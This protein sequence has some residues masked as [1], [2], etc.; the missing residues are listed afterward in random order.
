MDRHAR[1]DVELAQD[2]CRSPVGREHGGVHLVE[3]C[4]VGAVALEHRQRSPDNIGIGRRDIRFERLDVDRLPRERVDDRRRDGQLAPNRKAR[5]RDAGIDLVEPD[6]GVQLADRGPRRLPRRKE[7]ICA[8]FRDAEIQDQDQGNREPHLASPKRPQEGDEG[9]RGGRG[10]VRRE[11]AQR[12]LPLQE[13]DDQQ[14]AG[15]TELAG[16]R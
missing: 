16:P 1:V 7:H 14:Q 5:C 9:T 8:G 2:P 6:R 12:Q 13:E 4:G 15:E 3:G 11:R 10:N